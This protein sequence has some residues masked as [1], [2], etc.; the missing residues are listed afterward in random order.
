MLKR[1]ERVFFLISEQIYTIMINFT[2]FL[3]NPELQ[4]EERPVFT[5][6]FHASGHA[7]ENELEWIINKID[8]DII[9]PVHTENLEWFKE[10]Y[11]D[12]AKLLKR[13]EMFIVP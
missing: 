6:G 13:G 9:I 11:E 3:I 1:R 7:S 10:R 2:N 12:K 5:R 4:K 8:P